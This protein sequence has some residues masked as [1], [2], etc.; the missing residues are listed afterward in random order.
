MAFIPS[1][2]LV[3]AMLSQ[4]VT[5][6]RVAVQERVKEMPDSVLGE[7]IEDLKYHRRWPRGTAR[8]Q[9]EMERAGVMPRIYE[10]LQNEKFLREYAKGT[11]PIAGA[12]GMLSGSSSDATDSGREQ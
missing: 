12:I 10:A 5:G 9:K 11:P 3:A 7:A 4:G 2:K 1:R 8:L 6:F